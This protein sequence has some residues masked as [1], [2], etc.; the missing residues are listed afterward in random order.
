MPQWLQPL[1]HKAS[2]SLM[3]QWLQ[4]LHHNAAVL[5]YMRK[6]IVG[7]KDWWSA[8]YPLPHAEV[9]RQAWDNRHPMDGGPSKHNRENTW[10]QVK[11]IMPIF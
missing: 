11:T 4:Q 10:A 1:R 5:G 6:Y 8:A 3:P 9:L 7:V 2:P